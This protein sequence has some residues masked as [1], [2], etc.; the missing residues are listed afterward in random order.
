MFGLPLAE[1]EAPLHTVMKQSAAMGFE[2]IV[3]LTGHFGLEQP[4]APR[5]AALNAMLDSP[6]T[7]LPSTSYDFVTGFLC[8]RPC[9]HRRNVP[10]DCDATGVG[11]IE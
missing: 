1:V 4:L 6:V 8:R 7:I 10:D 9:R 5:R 11:A 2:V 3:M